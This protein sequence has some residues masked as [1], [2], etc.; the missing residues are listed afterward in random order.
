MFNFLTLLWFVNLSISY[1][2]VIYEFKGNGECLDSDGEKFINENLVYKIFSVREQSLPYCIE[3]CLK[4]KKCI[5]FELLTQVTGSNVKSICYILTNDLFPS[6]VINSVSNNVPFECYKK[7]SHSQAEVS[8]IDLGIGEC[9]DKNKDDLQGIDQETSGNYNDCE[10]LC[11]QNQDCIGFNFDTVS[12]IKIFKIFCRTS[13]IC[14]HHYAFNDNY[15]F[16]IDR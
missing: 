12:R 16:V 11:T 2:E 6:R 15:R 14:K 13:N 1:G 8:Y 10:N 5:G 3:E 7:I 4:E 9:T